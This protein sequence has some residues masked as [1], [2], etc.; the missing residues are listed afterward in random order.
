MVLITE[1][2]GPT[3]HRRRSIIATCLAVLFLVA[4]IAACAFAQ[5]GPDPV[6]VEVEVFPVPPLVIEQGEGLT[7]FAIDLWEEVGTPVQR[8]S[9]R[10]LTP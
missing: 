3:T 5:T 2:K 9:A 10:P 8:L 1:K 4:G 6:R 7:G